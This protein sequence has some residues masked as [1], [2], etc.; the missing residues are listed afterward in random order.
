MHSHA[1]AAGM[2]PAVPG[3]RFVREGAMNTSS[4]NGAGGA[5]VPSLTADEEFALV[6]RMLKGDQQAGDRLIRANLGLVVWMARRYTGRG[7]D[8]D[9]LI[10]E[11]NL[12]LIRAV[13][14]FRPDLGARFSTYAVFWI[15]Q[16]LRRALAAQAR[17]VRIPVG[18]AQGLARWRRA[19]DSL[20]E[21]LGRAPLPE[22]VALRL[23]L[24]GK[25]LDVLRHAAGV[26]AAACRPVQGNGALLANLCVDRRARPPE[27]LERAEEARWVRQLLD[28]LEERSALVL[29]LRFGLDGQGPRTLEAIG[30][31]L[32]L[33]RERVRKIQNKAL[34]R[35][36]EAARALRRNRR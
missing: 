21:E 4:D 36:R 20:R 7:L 25:R 3:R 28:Q 19:E 2:V 30:A 6:Q 32:G 24:T 18:T 9:D 15:R 11:G 1:N 13:H 34:E 22:E 12:G 23:A 35:L 17:P 10:A 27:V 29:H 26:L 5:P 16:H 14:S 31:V 8:L 33:T